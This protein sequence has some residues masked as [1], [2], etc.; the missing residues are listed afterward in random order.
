MMSF[1]A[2]SLVLLLCCLLTHT[3]PAPGEEPRPYSGAACGRG[4]DDY[5]SREV[6]PKVGSL[7]C[8]NC[9]QEGGDAEA[10]KLILKDPRKLQGHAQD[11]ALRHNREAFTRL[12]R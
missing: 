2:R 1:A 9:H 3:A 11:E 5:F 6:W 12:A 8:V 7:L 4:L 10:S